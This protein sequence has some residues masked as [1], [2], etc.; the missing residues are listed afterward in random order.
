MRRDPGVFEIGLNE[1]ENIQGPF[2]QDVAHESPRDAIHAAFA[3]YLRLNQRVFRYPVVRDRSSVLLYPF[4]LFNRHPRPHGDV[5]RKMIAPDRQNRGMVDR[6]SQE[7]D[8]VRC[9][10]ADINQGDAQFF[11][12]RSEDGFGARQ[13][14][15]DDA[16]YSHL[17][18]VDRVDQVLFE[19]LIA[20]HHVNIHIQSRSS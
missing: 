10:A 17:G 19:K 12:I 8:D 2:S 20:G 18:A 16:P 11:F 14:L 3:N 1:L 9:P 6:F 13:L 7:R 4:G 15:E 5:A